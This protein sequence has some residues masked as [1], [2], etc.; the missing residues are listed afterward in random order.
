MFI[1]V[2]HGHIYYQISSQPLKINILYI[3]V[4]SKHATK[5]LLKLLEM[6]NSHVYPCY[7]ICNNISL[8]TINESHVKI[9]IEIIER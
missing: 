3:N 7:S 6:I 1:L 4:L 2:I 9:S 5:T 8:K